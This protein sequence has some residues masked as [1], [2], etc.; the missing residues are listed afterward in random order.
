M[1]VSSEELTS[2]T[3][4]T[5]GQE[6]TTPSNTANGISPEAFQHVQESLQRGIE[7]A[8]RQGINI[9]AIANLTSPYQL[10]TPVVAQD[11]KVRSEIVSATPG[12]PRRAASSEARLSHQFS[13][14]PEKIDSKL[15]L[16]QLGYDVSK[17]ENYGG[18]RMLNSDPQR[19]APGGPDPQHH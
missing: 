17:L 5:D 19:V 18:R 8:A 11:P 1:L 16:R 6:V 15:I 14:L 10:S 7:D 2:R 13:T 12:A 3:P 9:M 4:I